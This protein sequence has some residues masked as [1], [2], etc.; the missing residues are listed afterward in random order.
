[1]LP[2]FAL[3]L[4]QVLGPLLLEAEA[5]DRCLHLLL[6][7]APLLALV[8]LLH[9]R[10]LLLPIERQPLLID[11]HRNFGEDRTHKGAKPVAVGVNNGVEFQ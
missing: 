6:L 8:A 1:M 4:A 11:G 9:W 5:L 10:H 2:L 7:L 3:D